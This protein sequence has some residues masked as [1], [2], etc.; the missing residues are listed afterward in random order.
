MIAAEYWCTRGLARRQLIGQE[1]PS[2]WGSAAR[3][4]FTCGELFLRGVFKISSPKKK[5]LKPNLRVRSPIKWSTMSRF[6][7]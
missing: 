1:H 4:F 7:P 5:F 2:G 3:A 6:A